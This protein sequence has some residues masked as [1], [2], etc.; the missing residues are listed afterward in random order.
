MASPL[1]IALLAAILLN[2]V[3]RIGVGARAQLALAPGTAALD[4][5]HDFC[6]AQGAAW[7]ARRDVMQRVTAALVEFAEASDELVESGREATIELAFDEYHIDATVR[8]VGRA[9]EKPD[10]GAASTTTDL[11]ETGELP[12]HLPL[13]IIGRMADKSVT[14]RQ[15]DTHWLHLSFE[16]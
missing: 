13:L 4:Q 8:Y 15:G 9:M 1:V 7:G 14:G 3:F 16:H 10:D 11:L 5:V 12:S 6:Q 2:L